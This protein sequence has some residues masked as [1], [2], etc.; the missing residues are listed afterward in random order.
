M[1]FSCCLQFSMDGCLHAFLRL[2][3]R[4]SFLFFDSFLPFVSLTPWTAVSTYSI[5]LWWWFCR[6]RPEQKSWS[7]DRDDELMLFELEVRVRQIE[8]RSFRRTN[9]VFDDCFCWSTH[10]SVRSEKE[11]LVLPFERSFL[12]DSSLPDYPYSHDDDDHC[13]DFLASL[14]ASL[15]CKHKREGNYAFSVCDYSCKHIQLTYLM[16]CRRDLFPSFIC[17]PLLSNSP[18]LVP[19]F[20]KN[21]VQSL[22]SPC[23]CSSSLTMM[24]LLFPWLFSWT[25]NEEGYRLPLTRVSYPRRIQ[26]QQHPIESFE[27]S[28]FCSHI[29]WKKERTD[30]VVITS[31]VVSCHLF[32]RGV[33]EFEFL[34][35][36]LCVYPF[37]MCFQAPCFATSFHAV[38]DFWVV[39]FL[40][41]LPQSLKHANFVSSLYKQ[42]ERN[43]WLLCPFFESWTLRSWFFQR[44][45]RM[46]EWL[47]SRR[48]K[49]TLILSVFVLFFFFK[50]RMS[51]RLC[52]PF[53]SKEMSSWVRDVVVSLDSFALSQW[54]HVFNSNSTNFIPR[55]WGPHDDTVVLE[56]TRDSSH[57]MSFFTNSL[58]RRKTSSPERKRFNAFLAVYQSRYK[59]ICSAKEI[60][61]NDKRACS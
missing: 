26:E 58:Q 22:C 2:E 11:K 5:L 17:L 16:T 54:L 24:M 55:E 13:I 53:D 40:P 35:Y 19:C 10:P 46:Q 28:P 60:E 48:S 59:N 36:L 7:N 9:S 51:C 38:H 41:F 45:I 39:L 31:L 49:E 56:L 15:V 18:L 14:M 47:S 1:F 20:Q 37:C 21:S 44:R 43:M 27:G 4:S 3:C 52:T 61:T 25:R 30:F 23:T 42:P 6:S 12:P 57:E 32:L 50:P 8:Q 33:R 29:L 34:Y